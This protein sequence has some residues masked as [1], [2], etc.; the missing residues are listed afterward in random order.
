MK[1]SFLFIAL[2]LAALFINCSISAAEDNLTLTVNGQSDDRVSLWSNSEATILVRA[3][4]AT[5][6]RFYHSGHNPDP[7]NNAGYLYFG[8]YDSLSYLEIHEHFS[9]TDGGYIFAQARYDDYQDGLIFEN[10][11][12]DENES[13]WTVT[14]KQISLNLE[15]YMSDSIPAGCVLDKTGE[16]PEYSRGEILRAYSTPLNLNEWYWA[17]LYPIVEGEPN[18]ENQEHYDF[19]DLNELDIPILGFD[20]G[21]YVLI[22]GASAPGYTDITPIRMHFS[23]VEGNIDNPT[24]IVNKTSVIVGEPVSIGIYAENFEEMVDLDLVVT[25]D[26]EPTWYAYNNYS[27]GG[28][29][30]V[31]RDFMAFDKAGIY[32]MVAASGNARLT[33]TI[34]VTSEGKLDKADLSDLSVLLEPGDDLVGDINVDL[35]TDSIEIKIFYIHYDERGWEQ[36][37]RSVRN[38]KDGDWNHLE[39]PGDLLSEEGLYCIEVNTGSRPKSDGEG[40]YLNYDSNGARMIFAVGEQ[41]NLVLEVNGSTADIESWESSKNLTID[42]QA[43]G[44]TAIRLLRDDWWDYQIADSNG[45]FRWEQGFEDGDYTIIAQMTTEDPGWEDPDFDWGKFRWEDLEWSDYSNPVKLHVISEMGELEA[46]EINLDPAGV[47]VEQGDILNVTIAPQDGAQW[48]WAELRELVIDPYDPFNRRLETVNY[49]H[50]DCDSDYTNLI[51]PTFQIAPG[52]YWLVVGINAEGYQ[53]NEINV[54]VTITQAEELPDYS[55][56]LSRDEIEAGEGIKVY[57]WAPGAENMN[58]EIFWNIDSNWRDYRDTG[59]EF[60][61][62]DCGFGSSGTYT[63]KLTIHYPDTDDVELWEPLTVT[64][65][66]KL[67]DPVFSNIPAVMNPLTS[68]NGSFDPI[69]GASWYDV[70]LF[71][72]QEGQDEWERVFYE[73][74]DPQAEGATTL[75]FDDFYFD[76]QGI[77]QL[78]VNAGARGFDTGYSDRRI[79]VLDLNDP[80]DG[81]TLSVNGKTSLAAIGDVL[82]HDDVLVSLEKPES[83]TAARVWSGDDW[84]IWAASDDNF[85]RDWYPDK[86]GT[87]TYVAQATTDQSVAQW[88]QEHDNDFSEFDWSQV[89]WDLTSNDVSFNVVCLGEL[90]APEL[91]L[92][93]TTVERGSEL[94]LSFDRVDNADMYGVIL[95]TTD[96]EWIYDAEY[97]EPGTYKLLTDTIP[98]G[99][100]KVVVESRR[101]GWRGNDSR[102][103]VTVTENSWTEQPVFKI[104]ESKVLTN[105]DFAAVISAP[106]AQEVLICLEDSCLKDPGDFWGCAEDE[107]LMQNLRCIDDGEWRFRGY[108]RYSDD[109]ELQQIGEEIPVTVTAS[110]ES[111]PISFDGAAYADVGEDYTFSITVEK[112]DGL[113]VDY[114]FIGLYDVED[115]YSPNLMDVLHDEGLL[116]ENETVDEQ[117]LH[118]SFTIPAGALSSGRYRVYANA[119]TN[120]MGY[121]MSEVEEFFDI[122]WDIQIRMD[123]VWTEGQSLKFYVDRQE[124][125]I[126]AEIRD[127]VTK[128]TINSC[129]LYN[130]NSWSCSFPEANFTPG[131]C[132]ELELS[133]GN[134]SARFN[135]CMMPSNPDTLKLPSGLTE[136]RESAFEET[137]AQKVVVPAGVEFI[138]QNAFA[139]SPNLML[140]ELQGDAESIDIDSEAFTGSEPLMVYGR[141]NPQEFGT[142]IREATFIYLNQ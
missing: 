110:K 56:I 91:V 17:D 135:L 14:S 136:I 49:G 63:L 51:I 94:T 2:I 106:G 81:L 32:Q 90:E 42:A 74:R 129:R 122:L 36:I 58:L 52:E 44:A 8:R 64:S 50:F 95:Q 96:G 80:A 28:D 54:P 79:L 53:G 62:W 31:V 88:R 34:E 20:P 39:V 30:A 68:I 133:E 131:Q 97:S 130:T 123:D 55:M 138:A 9:G 82:L 111:F 125:E 124:S 113:P 103:L 93:E 35:N 23:V 47:E 48:S 61:I 57:V 59:S 11:T 78:N 41:G 19:N 114:T 99:Q 115:E 60:E 134:K 1:R 73:H 84:D 76:E 83:V 105:E 98:A 26:G 100:Y 40:G 15:T 140:L 67:K 104:A 120:A 4:G 128:D 33:R 102:E 85:M 70:E 87:V 29:R 86:E 75:A 65:N 25:K 117:S 127:W 66:G 3:P 119:G 24:F 45:H 77:F 107:S 7:E 116:E 92:D 109:G 89:T 101:N 71:Y 21:N 27:N 142:R 72:I 69:Q 6:V 37:F 13:P 139:Y 12:W 137:A 18:W 22:V 46:P 38:N 132:Y 112:A 10:E 5:A 121:D 118:V 108:A 16:N 126:F 141:E 43:E